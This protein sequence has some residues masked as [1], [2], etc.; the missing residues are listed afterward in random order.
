MF[1]IR[2]KKLQ[3]KLRPRRSI[4]GSAKAPSASVVTKRLAKIPKL[5]RKV[6]RIFAAGCETAR[7]PE[8]RPV[9]EA[10][11]ALCANPTLEAIAAADLLVLSAAERMLVRLEGDISLAH[12]VVLSRGLADAV[13][14]VIGS[15]R[16]GLDSDGNWT[17]TMF[18]ITGESRHG[19]PNFDALRLAVCAA[20]DHEYAAARARALQI[21]EAV[22]L[23]ERIQLAFVFPDEPWADV[24]LASTDESQPLHGKLGLLLG[25]ATDLDVV[26]A[27]VQSRVGGYWMPHF[28]LD[29]AAALEPLAAVDLLGGSLAAL[30]AKPTYGPVMKTPP[31][32]VVAALSCLRMERTAEVLAPFL[33]HGILGAAVLAFFQENPAFFPIA[34]RLV[35]TQGGRDAVA[36][37]SAAQAAADDDTAAVDDSVVPSVLRDRPWRPRKIKK[38]KAV[39]VQG[40]EML[41]FDESMAPTEERFSPPLQVEEMDADWLQ[42]WRER[43][44]ANDHYAQA[45]FLWDPDSRIHW[46]VP[47]Q[48]GLRSWNEGRAMPGSIGRF[49]ERHGCD[50]IPGFFTT[51]WWRW[52][53]YDVGAEYYRAALRLRSPRTAPIIARVARRRKN[54]RRTAEHWLLRSPR[55]SAIGLI[56]G[57]VG[58]LGPFRE[59]AENALIVL[60][61]RG[62]GS[63]VREVAVEYGAEVTAVLE[64]L[65]NMDPLAVDLK[66]PKAP[67][68]L[69]PQDLPAVLIGDSKLPPDAVDSLLE[70]LRT[71]PVDPSYYGIELVSEACDR[72]SL[73]AFVGALIDQWV[74]NGA[75]GRH[76]WMLRA[77]LAFP[78]DQNTRKIGLLLRAWGAKKKVWAERA[79]NVLAALGTD[80]ALLHLAHVAETTRFASLKEQLRARLKEVAESRGLTVDEL[81]DR[82]VPDLGLGRHG[83]MVLS[84]GERTFAVGID[85]SLTLVVRDE[86][87]ERVRTLPPQRKTDDAALVKAAKARFQAFRK[88]L[89]SIADRQRRRLEWAMVGQR[90]WSR[91]DF[92]DQLSH[93][94]MSTVARGLVWLSGDLAFRVAEDLTFADVDDEPVELPDSEV[95]I[96]HVLD[97]GDDAGRWSETF[98]DYEIVQ[99]FAQLGRQCFAI[100]DSER[101]AMT[102]DRFMG[103]KKRGRN[104]I[105]YFEARG[106]RRSGNGFITAWLRNFGELIV[107]IPISPGIEMA[108]LREDGG[109]EHAVQRVALTGPAGPVAFGDLGAIAFSEVVRDLTGM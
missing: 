69:R 63:A 57:A 90:K 83:A 76:D 52:F 55:L 26:Q 89:E 74:N 10:A 94:V 59:D 109:D 67:D 54:Q 47:D 84:Y 22:A 86:T 20:D 24:D 36:S 53:T 61:R 9:R 46:R 42:R 17:R 58:E 23:S 6:S 43:T 21:R 99:P 85:E 93:P 104:M 35:I 56:P 27:Y 103:V 34:E 38:Q 105:G 106:W 39:V 28:A 7:E 92:V 95:R 37:L 79:A 82:T 18:V 77:A 101:I 48:E 68:Y 102:L 16:L 51:D 81:G 4:P 2:S 19:I 75:K 14:T 71:V 31:R 33:G 12:A 40:V 41:A 72:A 91:E 44:R 100:A 98:A 66:P 3:K 25:S 15:E 62:H 5:Y 64:R 70:M 80:V 8:L 73:E 96:A 107:E 60:V 87:G 50:A 32:D 49:V 65:L 108:Y 45:D 13:S 78:S 30:V 11:H 88:D 97:L 29:L 1:E